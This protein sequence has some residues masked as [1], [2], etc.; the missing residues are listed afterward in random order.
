MT[1]KVVQKNNIYSI[2]EERGQNLFPVV[3]IKSATP[4]DVARLFLVVHYMN[5]GKSLMQAMA[6]TLGYDVVFGDRP[7]RDAITVEIP[8]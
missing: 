6:A 4:D 1:H 3:H 8:Q 7:V 5:K 2:V